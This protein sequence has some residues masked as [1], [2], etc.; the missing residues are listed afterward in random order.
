MHTLG[1]L[2]AVLVLAVFAA[3]WA[4]LG[5]RP[6]WADDPPA[7]PASDVSAQGD[8]G[9]AKAKAGTATQP[10]ANDQLAPH[11]IVDLGSL[12]GVV[13]EAPT[14]TRRPISE[15][16]ASV[17]LVGRPKLD[18]DV[19]R[20]LS[21][22][23]RYEPGLWSAQSSNGQMGTPSIRGLMGNEVLLL[24]DGLR[25]NNSF[26]PTGPGYDWDLL[27]MDLIDHIEVLRT[28][29]S[30]IYGTDALGGVTAIY[31]GWPLDYTRWGTRVGGRV[32]LSVATGGTNQRRY[33]AR[34]QVATPRLRA[35]AGVSI[36]D[37]DDMVAG[38]HAG[39]QS[40]TAYT[41]QAGL[42]KIEARTTPRDRVGLTVFGMHKDFDGHFLF[43][44]RVQ[45]T[46]HQ[47]IATIVRWE[48]D[49]WT[50]LADTFEVRAGLAYNYRLVDR[51]DVIVKDKFRIYSPQV[52]LLAHKR[53]G[54]HEWTWGITGHGE[55]L[56]ATVTRAT[57]TISAVPDATTVQAGVFL[58][59]EWDVT[60]RVR[61][62]AGARFDYVRV[63]TDP[64]PATT[65]PLI[66]PDDI[67]IDRSDTALTG[68]LGVLYRVNTRV[69][70]TGNLARGYRFPSAQ[71]L[72]AFRQAPD[73]IIVGNPNLDPEYSTTVEGGLHLAYPRLRANGVVYYTWYE[74]LIIGR[75]GTFGGATYADINGN[76]MED[77]DEGF[78]IRQNAGK[79][80]TTGVDLDAEYD[81]TYAWLLFGNLSWWHGH[82]EP[83]PTEPLGLPTNATFGVRFHPTTRF[84][85]EGTVHWVRDFS[86][87]D[88][89]LYND[90]A[91]FLKDPHDRSKG[92]LTNDHTVPGFTTVDIRAG[93]TLWRR[94]RVS[95]GVENLFDTNY[96]WYGDRHDAP[97]VT[98]LFDASMDL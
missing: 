37:A 9:G 93:A 17:N 36:V 42:F 95:A 14:L 43:P 66:N 40:P 50:P 19:P 18:R 86:Y 29:D 27:D 47:R 64:N 5:A 4:S 15:T 51:T 32:G 78:L 88:P 20:S 56:H 44:S 41:S 23:L 10:V 71:D 49:A 61:V 53:V 60:P 67:R 2:R 39:T 68:K 28:P 25:M 57:G 35:T 92:T 8:G 76:G 85:A 22:A 3:C 54:H 72:A 45:N 59:D 90:E 58:Q 31:T 30:V 87:I 63:K 84:W 79:A 98:F 80:R 81:L 6:A 65:D 48:H 70:L 77:P 12:P 13:V 62:T 21:D 33:H 83:M 75:P 96:R 55:D 94:L 7:P 16:T 38:G 97:G 34:A 74:N 26:T 73:E 91:F 1:K 52:D 46:N 24:I 11:D 89:T 82:F 69:S